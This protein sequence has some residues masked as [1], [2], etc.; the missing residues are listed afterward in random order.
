MTSEN[1]KIFQTTTLSTGNLIDEFVADTRGTES[2]ALF[3][4]WSAIAA[5][6]GLAQRRV[7]CDI[8]KGKLFPNQYILL[9]SP[10][11][12][13]QIRSAEIGRLPLGA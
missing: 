12:G 7:W 5:I 1:D 8:G 10:S 9:V 2:P 6:A 13:R 11:W 3:R 4:K